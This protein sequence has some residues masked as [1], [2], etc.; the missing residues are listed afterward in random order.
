[1]HFILFRKGS[2]EIY[3]SMVKNYSD[4]LYIQFFVESKA[5]NVTLFEGKGQDFRD[6]YKNHVHLPGKLLNYRD[7]KWFRYV[8]ADATG[9][10]S[11]WFRKEHR[12]FLWLDS[13]ILIYDD[14]ESYENGEVNFLLHAKENNC[15]RMLS[16]HTTQEKTGY[17]PK[18]YS[19]RKYLSFNTHTDDEGHAKFAAVM[20]L[21]ESL[22]VRFEELKLAWKI[23]AGD[24]VVYINRRADGKVAHRNC[25]NNFDGIMTDAEIVVLKNGEYGAVNA[26]FIRR[27]GKSIL[28]SLA[29]V[30][31]LV[32]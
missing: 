23:T 6:N 14:I 22:D 24:T 31:G 27:D 19:E 29:R 26:S 5:H 12:H 28:E 16:P 7:E 1:G 9:P 30:T 8:C 20:L 2:P 25:V 13:F 4:P 15:F 21:D 32:K 18:D 11:R 10:M 3:D 17:N